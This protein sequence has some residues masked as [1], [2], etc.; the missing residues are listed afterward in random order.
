MPSPNVRDLNST[1]QPTKN[2]AGSVVA[3]PLRWRSTDIAVGAA[4]GVACG[5]IFWGFDFVY[6]LL[7]PLLGAVLPGLSSLLH[8]F[9]YFSGPLAILIIRKPGAGIYTNLVGAILE[10]L[11]G[12][13]YS[14]ISVFL[15]ALAE[16]LLADIPFAIAKYRKFTLPR[17][18]FSGF[19]IA[20]FYGIYVLLTRLQG[21]SLFSVRGIVSMIC[22]IISGILIAGVMSWFLYLAIARTGALDRF[23][24]GRAVKSRK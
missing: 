22:E 23:A 1:S 18:V 10:I 7:S 19:F 14:V 9:W 13:G 21:V 12:N 5:V 24:S 17:S 4:L 6:P 8:G 15:P 16:G 3:S 20:I 11:F 2:E